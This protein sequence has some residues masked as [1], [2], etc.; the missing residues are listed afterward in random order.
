MI[1]SCY[2]RKPSNGACPN[3]VPFWA[4]ANDKGVCLKECEA[5]LQYFHKT[6]QDH[7]KAMPPESRNI[8][9]AN[10]DVAACGAMESMTAADSKKQETTQKALCKAVFKHA[11]GLLTDKNHNIPMRLDLRGQLE[12]VIDV[13]V[14]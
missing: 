1:K 8:L 7:T 2:R 12:M 14:G 3:P 13:R 11:L 4:N 9:L 10:V 6:L 5:L